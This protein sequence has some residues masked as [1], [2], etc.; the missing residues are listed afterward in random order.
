MF[1]TEPQ[2][3]SWRCACFLNTNMCP[4]IQASGLAMNLSTHLSI[5][6]SSIHTSIHHP[7]IYS[8]LHPSLHLSIF[9]LSIHNPSIILPSLIHSSIHLS[10]YPSVYPS[11]IH[12]SSFHLSIHPTIH[13]LVHPRHWEGTRKNGYKLRVGTRLTWFEF[14]VHILLAVNLPKS[15]NISAPQYPKL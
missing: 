2:S 12:S 11:I 15:F 5:H 1:G 13:H 9:P 3:Q 10:I 7:S 14:Q 8:S 4:F 6:P